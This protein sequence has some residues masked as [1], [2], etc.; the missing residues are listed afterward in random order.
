MGVLAVLLV[1]LP[2]PLDL[3]TLTR[4][5]YDLAEAF[6]DNVLETRPSGGPD[7]FSPCVGR[8][9]AADAGL[10]PG[11]RASPTDR[12]LRIRTCRP[13]YDFG[14]ERGPIVTYLALS[15]WWERRVP[16]VVVWYG[17]D[18]PRDRL[19][20]L[21]AARRQN[22]LDHFCRV[23]HRPYRTP[24]WPHRIAEGAAL[25]RCC[26]LPMTWVGWNGRS[27]HVLRCLACGHTLEIPNDVSPIVE[28]RSDDR[29]KPDA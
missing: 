4:L 23:G 12:W 21:D 22:L 10:L 15:A 24:S 7:G 1:E 28:E 17:P 9:Q 27:I 14:Y 6:G 29:A 13:Y 19:A 25:P 16:G 26:G 11:N 5:A 2:S 18:E 8:V 3:A 20:P